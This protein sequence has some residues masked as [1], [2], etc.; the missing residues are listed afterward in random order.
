MNQYFHIKYNKYDMDEIVIKQPL[1][2]LHLTNSFIHIRYNA[3]QLCKYHLFLLYFEYNCLTTLQG[4]VSSALYYSQSRLM[5][6]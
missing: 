6:P 2:L 3:I 1:F 4:T 5:T